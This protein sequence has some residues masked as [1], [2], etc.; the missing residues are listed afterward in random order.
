MVNCFGITLFGKAVYELAA[1]VYH[2]GKGKKG[3]SNVA[4]LLWKFLNDQELLSKEE[5][6]T[7]LTIIMDNCRGQN[8]NQMVLHMAL[9][10]VN[11]NAYK[12]VNFV[13]LVAGHT[14]NACNRLFNLLKIEYRKCDMF[15]MSQLVTQLSCHKLI[16]V[17]KI[18]PNEFKD[19]DACWDIHYKWIEN[20]TVNHLHFF[21]VS[22]NQPGVL[23]S[24]NTTLASE[25]QCK[26][27]IAKVKNNKQRTNLLLQFNFASLDAP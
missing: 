12:K 4:S 10:L 19:M 9:F 3:K 26:Q 24:H 1:F 5:P 18:D 21:S 8:K 2:K 16:T 15:P 20:G 22:N 14:K 27:K 25:V 13:F 17:Y 6:C 23:V 7:E 11:I